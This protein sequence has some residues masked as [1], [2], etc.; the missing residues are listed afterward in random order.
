MKNKKALI[1]T[2][3]SIFIT[4]IIVGTFSYFQS[5]YTIDNKFR[6]RSFSTVIQKSLDSSE[7]IPGQTIKVNELNVKNTGTTKVAVRAVIEEKATKDDVEIPLY[8]ENGEK[9]YQPTIDSENWI[10]DGNYYYYKYALDEQ[11]QTT[12]IVSE[13]YFNKN[14]SSGNLECNTNSSNPTSIEC[15]S[16]TNGYD[17]AIYKLTVRFDMIQIEGMNATWGTYIDEVGTHKVTFVYEDGT[18]TEK[19]VKYGESYGELPED[20]KVGHDFLGW[21]NSNDE[22]ILSTS[23]VDLKKDITLTSKFSTSS[24]TV[25][26]DATGGTSDPE[27]KKVEYQTTYGTL[28]IPTYPGHNFAG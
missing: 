7:W 13:L 9:T 12:N 16:G 24:Y 27:E 18:T 19:V 4:G 2:I 28:P 23:I 11:E 17:D 15:T 14:A 25:T 1:F 10:Y 21:F 6:A 5:T 3:L 26:F 22:Q 8:L 20:S